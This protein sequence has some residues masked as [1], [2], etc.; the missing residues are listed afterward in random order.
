M[1]HFEC[2]RCGHVWVPRQEKRPRICPKCLPPDSVISGEFKEI[3]QYKKG[4]LV[5]G[6]SGSEGSVKQVLER[7]YDGKL[8]RLKAQ[9]C[10]SIGVTSDHKVLVVHAIQKCGGKNRKFHR[11]FPSPTW[12]PAK[13]LRRRPMCE[14]KNDCGDFVVIPKLKGSFTGYELPISPFTNKRGLS[15]LKGKGLPMVF[16]LNKISA[17]LLGLY[18]AEGCSSASKGE[19]IFCLGKHEKDLISQTVKN[20]K[21]IGYSAGVRDRQTSSIVILYSRVLCRAFKEWCGENAH[22]KRIPEFIINHSDLD[23]VSA[24]LKGY[25]L[26]DGNIRKHEG[27]TQVSATTVSK[28]LALQLQLLSV[29]LSG[30][31]HITV[32]DYSKYESTAP[33]GHIIK[34]GIQYKVNS[35]SNSIIKLFDEEGANRHNKSYKVFDNYVLV[36]I[37]SVETIDYKG[38]VMNLTTNEGNYLVSNMVVKNCK[39]PYWD[40]ERRA[41]QKPEKEKGGINE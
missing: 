37:N 36:P 15:V 17:W 16:K 12:V 22:S 1:P 7:D 10:L 34:G 40:V 32:H 25:I 21:S 28:T 19:L 23:I 33:D 35:S 41:R 11:E 13:E 38:K 3:S 39:S 5:Y 4:D 27:R 30:V 24:F 2:K 26:G 31:F 14:N 8:V 29:R 9:G 6:Y 18:V 20:I